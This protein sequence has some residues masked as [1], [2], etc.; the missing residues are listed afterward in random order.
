[1][2]IASVSFRTPRPYLLAAAAFA[3]CSLSAH[4]QRPDA[5]D[6]SPKL[7]TVLADLSRS[8]SQSGPRSTAA[9]VSPLNPDSLPRSVQD[10][11]RGGLLRMNASNEVQVYILMNDVTDATVA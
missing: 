11:M 6:V 10:A 5:S 9:R 8:V 2:S 4:A 1:M 7:T 3:L